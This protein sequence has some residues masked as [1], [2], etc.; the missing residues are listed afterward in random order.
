MWFKG[1]QT[2][3]H[4]FNA[5]CIYK[6]NVICLNQGKVK[7]AVYVLLSLLPPSVFI[8]SNIPT[9]HHPSLFILALPFEKP[10]HKLFIS[11]HLRDS[12]EITK[13]HVDTMP[14]E[15]ARG[16]FKLSEALMQNS[17]SNEEDGSEDKAQ[18]L[19]DEAEI[20][21]LRRDES[22]TEFGKE[23]VYDKWV[24]IFWR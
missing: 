19:R 23:D 10:S 7:A 5:G 1:D 12:L 22:A 24:P 16:L 17:S 21:L 6:T 4:P 15:H 9:H 3:L 8:L 2:R 13:F 11:R 18:D 14:V 20:Y